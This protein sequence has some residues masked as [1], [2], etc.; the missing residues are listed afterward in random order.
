M[1]L[2]TEEAARTTQRREYATPFPCIQS[3]LV[4]RQCNYIAS[5]TFLIDLPTIGAA[6]ACMSTYVVR[7]DHINGDVGASP[8]IITGLTLSDNIHNIPTR[9]LLWR[10]NVLVQMEVNDAEK[11]LDCSSDWE[12]KGKSWSADLELTI[13]WTH[14]CVCYRRCFNQAFGPR[15]SEMHNRQVKEEGAYVW[16]GLGEI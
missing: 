10:L 1:Y 16:T 6:L 8:K 7:S 5:N 13:L 3:W 4:P 14:T 9:A 12:L 2:V 15:M 11:N